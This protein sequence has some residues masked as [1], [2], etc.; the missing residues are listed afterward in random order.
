MKD[1][2]SIN[3]IGKATES[4]RNLP[5]HTPQ[6][7]MSKEGEE[8][9]NYKEDVPAMQCIQ[10]KYVPE[11]DVFMQNDESK[12]V[13]SDNLPF[14][15]G[16][17]YRASKLFTDREPSPEGILQRAEST[18]GQTPTDQS[19]F[20]LQNPDV[21]KEET[22][23]EAVHPGD[24][25][26][27]VLIT[28]V[29]PKI[30]EPQS[31]QITLNEKKNDLCDSKSQD[32]ICLQ[33]SEEVY[34]PTNH[35]AS[36]VSLKQLSYMT[37]DSLQQGSCHKVTDH[38]QCHKAKEGATPSPE[39]FVQSL[40]STPSQP[41]PLSLGYLPVFTSQRPPD[42]PTT[43]GKRRLSK[44]WNVRD[45]APDDYGYVWAPLIIFPSNYPQQI[46]FVW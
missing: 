29:R 8:H 15:A 1:F 5:F 42:L 10:D 7:N 4:E 6:W 41:C 24:R 22:Q 2:A 11:Y 21:A 17:G 38:L 33:D 26:T 9:C 13:Q 27:T 46:V 3:T 39:E 23:V 40:D 12:V 34:G 43:M 32:R 19:S 44:T 36:A 37:F 30:D 35:A 16:D 28:S 14:H 45:T 25:G 31:N 20:I 18:Q